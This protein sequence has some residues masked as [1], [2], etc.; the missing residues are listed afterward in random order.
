[1]ALIRKHD[2]KVYYGF[3]QKHDM[4]NGLR[5][6]LTLP[7]YSTPCRYLQNQGDS[8]GVWFSISN[9]QTN[10]IQKEPPK[11][12]RKTICRLIYYSKKKKLNNFYLKNMEGIK[13]TSSI[14]IPFWRNLSL[15][16]SL[17][18]LEIG[19]QLQRLES[20]KG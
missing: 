15:L 3:A 19:S 14:I 1:M 8:T 12:S 4:K 20:A 11:T 16:G 18:F 9:H 10:G 6:C 17:R 7:S 2:I 13:Y 5:F